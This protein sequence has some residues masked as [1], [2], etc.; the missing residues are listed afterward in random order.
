MNVA[1]LK[2]FECLI[3]EQKILAQSPQG[4]EFADFE[5]WQKEFPEFSESLNKWSRESLN[6]L[7]RA[8]VLELSHRSISEGNLT[9]AFLI[10]MV[11]GYS[12]DARGPARTR[13]I[14]EQPNFLESLK[15]ALEFLA[16]NKIAEAYESLVVSGPKHLSTSFGSKL[17]YFFA[18]PNE[19]IHPLIFD[20]RIFVILEELGMPVGNS[21]V[22]TSK[23]YMNY[24]ELASSLALKYSLSIGE[25]EEHLF[26]FSGVINGNYSWKRKVTFE[27]L[28][29]DQ[30][31]SLAAL[32]ANTFASYLKDQQVLI[33]GNGGG[34]YGG[35]VAT[36]LI[37]EIEYEL[38]ATTNRNV[39]LIAPEFVRIHWDLVLLRGIAQSARDLLG[40]TS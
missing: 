19:K 24:I 3:E 4:K 25:I 28:S 20:R 36:G 30:R 8:N 12:G 23:Q 40:I 13:L 21:P 34:Q 1:L 5:G 14:I 35:F 15:L 37:A 11:W 33:N 18:T 9:E 2:D 38:H 10:V 26:I 32:L 29:E 39:N 17:L 16:E 27:S 31:N 22:L 7:D 6:F